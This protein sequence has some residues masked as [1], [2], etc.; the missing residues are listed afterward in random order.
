MKNKELAFQPASEVAEKLAKSCPFSG[1]SSLLLAGQHRL[2]HKEESIISKCLPGVLA[3]ALGL[4][5]ASPAQAQMR[6]AIDS[7][8]YSG[9]IWFQMAWAAAALLFL[10]VVFIHEFSIILALCPSAAKT[11]EATTDI[12][13][14]TS[15]VCA[16]LERIGIRNVSALRHF[17]G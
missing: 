15:T 10:A 17:Q 1:Q 8:G 11:T 2:H 5:F 3:A 4:V 7:I 14:D 9:S 16:N 13:L 12:E 6:N